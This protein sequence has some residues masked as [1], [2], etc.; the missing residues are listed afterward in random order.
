MANTRLSQTLL[1]PLAAAR[2]T[3]IPPLEA[4]HRA[5]PTPENLPAAPTLAETAPERAGLALPMVRP[6]REFKPP[7]EKASQPQTPPGPVSD[8]PQLAAQNTAAETSLAIVSLFPARTPQIPKPETS[9]QA[10]FSAGSQPRPEGGDDAPVPGQL[11]VPGL[12]ARSGTERPDQRSQALIA[13]T[14]APPTSVANLMAAARGA[15]VE[16]QLPPSSLGGA[17]HIAEAPD[18]RLEGRMVYSMAL[19]MPNIT[20]YSGSWIVWFAERGSTAPRSPQPP[21]N[22]TPPVPVHKVDPKYVPAAAEDR[23]EGNVRL[24][25][26]IRK[27]GHVDTVEVLQGLDERLDRSAVE[28][29]AK[30]EFDPAFHNGEAIEVDAVFNIPFHL[31]PRLAR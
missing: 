9:Q 10:G 26:V 17:V 16:Q 21:P 25:A 31:A 19:Q 2:K 11:A 23:K 6:L 14:F 13:A 18:K 5:V 24:A 20:S 29:L 8:A 7:S 28:A 12:L 15:R 4:V 22:L 27:D 30:W 3:F 1:P